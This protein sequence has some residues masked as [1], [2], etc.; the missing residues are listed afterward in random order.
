MYFMVAF[1]ACGLR[2]NDR[3]QDVDFAIKETARKPFSVVDIVLFNG[4]S[5]MLAIRLNE[6]NSVVDAF[7]I[8]EGTCSF[9]GEPKLLAF[10]P[11]DVRLSEVRNKM[12]YKQ[13]PC[14]KNS[15][16][17]ENEAASRN[18]AQRAFADTKFQTISDKLNAVI[19]ASDVDE[20]PRA[21]KLSNTFASDDFAN[22]IAQGKIYRVLGS[23]FYYNVRCIDCTEPNTEKQWAGARIFAANMLLSPRPF[24]DWRRSLKCIDLVDHGWHFSFF[25][26]STQIQNKLHTF[27]HTEFGQ[28]PYDTIEHINEHRAKCKDLFD[29]RK[30]CF[31][32]LPEVP[33]LPVWME[34][35]AKNGQI[36]SW[37]VSGEYE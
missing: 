28:A 8:L 23:F 16:A 18:Y 31:H 10:D 30:P 26:N 37:L 32:R 1:E 24:Q 7:L 34:Q 6:L 4:E 29:R 5:D 13:M 14:F 33:L 11:Q 20:I 2:L 21:N 3:E 35:A 15:N 17:W 9:H 19:I 36:P 25:L 27:S 22:N 12:V